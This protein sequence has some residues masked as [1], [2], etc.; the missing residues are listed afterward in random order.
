MSYCFDVLAKTWAR[1]REQLPTE[2][3]DSEQVERFGFLLEELHEANHCQRDV[4]NKD[5]RVT[6]YARKLDE[7][8]VPRENPN[9]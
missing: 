4:I 3:R 8:E 5:E 9:P 7:M 2:V 1:I 6:R